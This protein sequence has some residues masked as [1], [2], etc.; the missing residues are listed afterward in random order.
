VINFVS[1]CEPCKLKCR[2]LTKD[3]VP[4]AP[5]DRSGLSGEHIMMDIIGPIDPPSSMRHKYILNVICL[6][7]RWPFSYLLRDLTAKSVCECLC[8]VFSYMGVASVVSSDCGSNFTS[9]LTTYFLECL[10]CSPRFNMP[11]HPEASGTVER[12]NQTFKK[13]LHHAISTNAR[14]WHKCVPFILWAL[15]ESGNETTGLL[16]YTLLYGHSPRGPL[17]ILKESWTG[18]KQLPPRL[19]KSEIQY[20]SELKQQLEFV[21][22]YADCHSEQAQ[23]DYV[24]AY[25]KRSRDKSFELGEK[26]IVLFGDSTNKLQSKWQTGIVVDIADEHSYLIEMPNGGRKQIHANHLRPFKCSCKYCNCS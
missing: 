20:M 15:R 24:Y 9:A 14:Q 10:G 21:R 7:T 13:M 16:P 5:V 26:V 3:R 19:K 6:H 1:N 23:A 2:L 4:I 8:D 11:A 22:A 18:S 17:H 25:N 12:F